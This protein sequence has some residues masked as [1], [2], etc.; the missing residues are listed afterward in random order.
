MMLLL[1]NPKYCTYS[2]VTILVAPIYQ[3]IGSGRCRQKY[4]SQK[5]SGGFV[6]ESRV[7]VE[8]KLQLHH[9]PG[10]GVPNLVPNNSVILMKTSPFTIAKIL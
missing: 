7:C 1:Y 4:Q 6:S 2:F 8:K 10:S 5:K 9:H 3:N